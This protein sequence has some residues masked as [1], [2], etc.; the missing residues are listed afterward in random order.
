MGNGRYILRRTLGEGGMGTVWLAH[1]EVLGELVALKFLPAQV[2]ADPSAL[3]YLRDETLQS[4]R[5]AH[6]NIVKIFN[7]E[8]GGA[9][10]SFI[11]MEYVDGPTLSALRVEQKNGVFTWPFLEP[12]VKQLLGALDYAHNE[13]VIH[14]DLKPANIMLD[15]KNQVKL[16]DFGIARVMA[17][18]VSRA[19]VRRN[20]SGTLMYMSPQQLEGKSPR[21]TDDVYSL[22]ATLYELLTGRP[23]FFSGEILHQILH[24]EAEPIQQRLADLGVV[25]PIPFEVR[26]TINECLSKRPLDRPQSARD[27]EIKLGLAAPSPVAPRP[28]PRAILIESS[29]APTPPAPSRPPPDT[30]PLEWPEDISPEA[31]PEP[32]VA[33]WRALWLL[34]LLLLGLIA[35]HQGGLLPARLAAPFTPILG[36]PRLGPPTSPEPVRE[37]Q[38]GAPPRVQTL[39]TSIT[40]S[41]DLDPKSTTQP[42]RTDTATTSSPSPSLTPDLTYGRGW[43]EVR[44][45]GVYPA[46]QY[47]LL[48]EADRVVESGSLSAPGR[49]QGFIGARPGTYGLVL[50]NPLWR[51]PLRE[52]VTLRR[53]TT[54]LFEVVM[55]ELLS[56]PLGAAVVIRGRTVGV[57]PFNIPVWVNGRLEYE[58]RLANHESKSVTHQLLQGS[59]RAFRDI[60]VRRLHPESGVPW[61][62]GMGM[63]FMA[64]TSNLWV[65]AHETRWRDYT[66]FYYTYESFM[67]RSYLLTNKYELRFVGIGLNRGG[68]PDQPIVSVRWR[69]A[70]EFCRWLTTRDRSRGTLA[71]NWRYRLPTDEEWS[72][73]AGLGPEQGAT[74]Q[75]RGR[76]AYNQP[77]YAWGSWPANTRPP[78]S[79]GNFGFAGN[80]PFSHLAPVLALDTNRVGLFHITGNV[81]EW[82][83]DAF[84]P[85]P[86]SNDS[87]NRRQAARSPVLRTLRGGSY[88]TADREHLALGYRLGLD[89]D[90]ADE[91]KGFRI[92]L[93]AE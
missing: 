71:P 34:V 64:V 2:R 36:K 22:G 91:D 66:N 3:S 77:Q 21:P 26:T 41:P 53:D 72:L 50:S 23:P 1:D 49:G 75:E 88:L 55:A 59:P 42:A 81:W 69:D 67:P 70:V 63:T 13:R 14:R 43:L 78:A 25:N 19:E 62:N 76:N 27:L 83:E 93:S 52:T 60:L 7:L 35:A 68:N 45:D 46:S 33:G 58:L 11:A 65:C 32:Q 15:G 6:P 29:D 12:L 61:T 37:T 86:A 31:A 40:T 10:E 5:L 9:G 20:V 48:D 79:A 84:G 4:R 47:S 51:V 57:T 90:V 87:G 73:A 17:D 56:D 89:P 18:T 24:V 74:P 28:R 80:D 8:F 44:T 85:P 39:P 82:C 54:N 16:A 38:S 30:A 92:V